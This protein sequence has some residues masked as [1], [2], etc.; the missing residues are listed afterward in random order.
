ME[1]HITNNKKVIAYRI[2]YVFKSNSIK[3]GRNYL[4]ITQDDLIKE[5]STK[6]DI[7]VATVRKVFK[8]ADNTIFDYLSSTPPIENISIKIF[9]GLNL[10]R[11]YVPQKI[12]S[13][14]M[15]RNINS[16]E[17]CNIFG[18]ITNYYKNKI[19]ENLFTKKSKILK[20]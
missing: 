8:S 3:D 7:D 16:L 5:I 20:G 17:H 13:K 19:N 6:E 14:G 2:R 11:K 12:Y 4:I 1:R 18:V 10:N 15:F 9:N